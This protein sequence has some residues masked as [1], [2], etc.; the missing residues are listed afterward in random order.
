MLLFSLLFFVFVFGA[1]AWNLY[2]GHLFACEMSARAAAI[3]PR[4]LRAEIAAEIAAE[5]AAAAAWRAERAAR[6]EG[7]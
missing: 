7:R 3:P 1:F 4:D 6:W 2:T 5:V